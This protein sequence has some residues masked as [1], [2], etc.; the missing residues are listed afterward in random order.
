MLQTVFWI[1][2][3]FCF[4]LFSSLIG[5]K[6]IPQI[7]RTGKK[8]NPKRCSQ[9]DERETVYCPPLVP[10]AALAAEL[11]FCIFHLL[12]LLALSLLNWSWPFFLV[13]VLSLLLRFFYAWLPNREDWIYKTVQIKNKRWLKWTHF[14]VFVNH[15]KQTFNW[16]Y[17][18]KGKKTHWT[19]V[20]FKLT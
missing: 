4:V 9:T 19:F 18:S 2:T 20:V 16:L 11:F 3:T 17:V 12:F 6:S 10:T 14:T 5:S 13:S 15:L 8:E 7:E 1:K